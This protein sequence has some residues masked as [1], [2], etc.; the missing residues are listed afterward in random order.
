MAMFEA[1]E[2]A[3]IVIWVE[4]KWNISKIL[5]KL[6]LRFTWILHKPMWLLV[7]NYSCPDA[8]WRFSLHNDIH[9]LI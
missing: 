5:H 6:V 4:Q 3:T 8:I 9:M 7:Y 2:E 1:M